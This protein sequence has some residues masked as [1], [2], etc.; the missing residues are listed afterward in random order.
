MPDLL[1][2]AEAVVSKRR[3]TELCVGMV[4]IA[5]P[6]GGER[7][8][9]DHLSQRLTV[10]G[11]Q[12]Q[13]QQVEGDLSNA[14]GHLR[15]P[16]SGEDR[17]SAVEALLLYAPIDTVTTGQADEDLPWAGD[18]VRP[19]MQ[20]RARVEDGLVIGLGA[21]NPKGH[22][23]CILAAVEIVAS[24][25][26]ELGRDLVVGFGGGGMPTNGRRPGIP[27]AHGVGCAALLDHLAQTELDVAEAVI[28]KSG[29]AV[30]WEEVG[31]AWYEVEVSG[32]HTYAGSRHLLPYRNAIAD[33]GH[34]IGGLEQWFETWAS[35]TGDELHAPQGVVSAIEGGWPHM[36]SFTTALCRFWIDLRLH[37]MMSPDDADAMFGAEIQRIGDEIGADLTWKRTVTIPGSQTEQQAAIVQSSIHAWEALT[38]ATHQP[39]AKLSGATDANI[40]RAAGLPTARVGLPKVK[41]TGLDVDFAFG[42]NAV[43][44]EDMVALTKLLIRV[45]LDRCGASK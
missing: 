4:D 5:S 13:T 45:I 24:L 43:D 2:A 35:D 31:L 16:R 41:R 42:M 28:A 9:A 39:I 32:T 37:P 15:A 21:Q 40:L 38:G 25:D 12:G 26:V 19:D 34:L 20:A 8:L 1:A 23:A 6:P 27:N 22:G 10:A 30:S 44:I 33:A 11:L 18:A 3:L 36:P 7:D 14:W 17:D 29:W